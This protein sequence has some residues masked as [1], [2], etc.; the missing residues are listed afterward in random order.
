MEDHRPSLQLN[1][2]EGVEREHAE[3]LQG[4]F[5]TANGVSQEHQERH[6]QP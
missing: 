4:A 2:E 5:P 6:Y 1:P 3:S